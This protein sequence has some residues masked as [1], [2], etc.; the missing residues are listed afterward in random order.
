VVRPT[1]LSAFEGSLEP[2][3]ECI[4]RVTVDVRDSRLNI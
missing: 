3:V 1:E 2:I 4:A